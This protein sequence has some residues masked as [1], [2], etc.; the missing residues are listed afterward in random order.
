MIPA[1]TILLR[2]FPNNSCR[3][4]SLLDPKIACIYPVDIYIFKDNKQNRRLCKICL[5]LTIKTPEWLHWLRFGVSIGHFEHISHLFLLISLLS[6]LL[7]AIFFH[8]P[9]PILW[10]SLF[11]YFNLRFQELFLSVYCYK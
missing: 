4:R 2:S 10:I 5:K 11:K 9:F 1:R 3:L 7:C 6:S 8:A